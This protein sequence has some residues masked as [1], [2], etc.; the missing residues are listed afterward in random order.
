LE[1]TVGDH[2]ATVLPLPAAAA[3]LRL[4]PVALEA[5]VGSGYLVPRSTGPQGPEFRL[6]DLKAF[7]A[8]NADKDTDGSLIG[9]HPSLEDLEQADPQDLLDALDARAEEMARRVYDLFS[10]VFPDA[11]GWGIREQAKFI[12]QATARF[13]AI[14][15]VTGQGSEVD[16]ALAGDL[17]E[18]GARAARAG[19]PLPRL[20]VILRMSRDLVVQTAVELA[21]GRGRHWGLSLSLLLTRVLPAMDRLTD[22]LAQG[23]WAA[24]LSREGEARARYEHVVVHAADGVYDVDLDGRI[25]FANPALAA[26][27]GRSGEEL[28]GVPLSDVLHPVDPGTTVEA[29]FNP[30]ASEGRLTVAIVRPDGAERVL[31]IQ[32]LPRRSDAEVVGFQG[33]VRDETGPGS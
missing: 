2:H 23:Y 25:R 9:F 28:I 3:L 7:V 16:E 30:D 24:I 20:L 27:V 33:I 8:R 12:E 21:E 10:T 14:L 31:G 1:L 26:M 18:V 17:E 15:A 22:A 11:A 13:E 19:S 4:P 5:L 6:A 32:T 29:L